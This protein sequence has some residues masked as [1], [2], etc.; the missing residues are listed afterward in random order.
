MCLGLTE[1]RVRLVLYVVVSVRFQFDRVPCGDGRV[2]RGGEL[3]RI[4]RDLSGGCCAT[5]DIRLSDRIG[6]S[7]WWFG[8]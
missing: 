4:E 5:H 6:Y 1:R 2:R 3:H 7:K 8:L